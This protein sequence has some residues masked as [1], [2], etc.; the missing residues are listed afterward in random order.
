MIDV[1]NTTTGIAQVIAI[2]HST[3][4]LHITSIPYMVGHKD[5][6]C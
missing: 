4:R 5:S 6:T 3:Y 1:K 2:A